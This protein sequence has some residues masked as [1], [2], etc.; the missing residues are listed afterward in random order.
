MGTIKLA[1]SA[2]DKCCDMYPF[3]CDLC[4]SKSCR[5]DISFQ[6]VLKID[7]ECYKIEGTFHIC[8]LQKLIMNADLEK[9]Y[10]TYYYV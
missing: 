6:G 5:E 7:G 2:F 1:G 9:V 10:M 3:E 4:I 8:T